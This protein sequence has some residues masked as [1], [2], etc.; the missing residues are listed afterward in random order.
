MKAITPQPQ[1]AICSDTG[2]FGIF[3]TLSLAGSDPQGARKALAAIPDHLLDF[4]RPVTGAAFFAP[5]LDLLRTSMP[6]AIPPI[7]S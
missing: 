1:A 4:S 6:A 2:D 7:K 5:S 3:L